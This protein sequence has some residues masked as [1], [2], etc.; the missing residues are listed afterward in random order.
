MLAAAPDAFPD[1]HLPPTGAVLPY[2]P[3]VPLAAAGAGAVV[4]YG[5]ARRDAR[6]IERA[7]SVALRALGSLDTVVRAWSVHHPRNYTC[8]ICIWR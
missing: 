4:P 3:A 8:I 5:P 2:A 1:L 6:A 7:A